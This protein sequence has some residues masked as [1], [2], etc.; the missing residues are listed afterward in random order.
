MALIHI[1][2]R[3]YPLPEGTNQQELAGAVEAAVQAKGAVTIQ[4]EIGG[5]EVTLYV[6]T[7]EVAVIALDWNGGGAG[8]FH[9]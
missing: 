8:F 9:G 1:D 6:N 4:V 7:A 3:T 2:G 5:H